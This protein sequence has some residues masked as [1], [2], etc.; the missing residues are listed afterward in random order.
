MIEGS[1]HPGVINST[2]GIISSIIIHKM[3]QNRITTHHLECLKGYLHPDKATKKVVMAVPVLD[4]T[5]SLSISYQSP[6]QSDELNWKSK[7]KR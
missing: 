5:T 3:D 6:Q 4:N 1:Y 2:G 7:S